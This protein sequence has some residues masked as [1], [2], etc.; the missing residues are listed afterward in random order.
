MGNVNE[1]LAKVKFHD[2]PLDFLEI[3]SNFSPEGSPDMIHI[4]S[5]LGRMEMTTDEFLELAH[6]VLRAG[7][8]FRKL[9]GLDFNGINKS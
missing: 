3:E 5:K 8:Q 4:H 6:A 1:V 7:E 2:N 9:K